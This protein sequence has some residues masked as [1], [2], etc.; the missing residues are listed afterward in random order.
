MLKAIDYEELVARCEQLQHLTFEHPKFGPTPLPASYPSFCEVKAHVVASRLT[1]WGISTR[2]I[3]AVRAEPLLQTVSPF[4]EARGEIHENPVHQGWG[5]HV[6]PLVDTLVDGRPT[7]RVIDPYFSS[8]PLTEEAWLSGMGVK[9]ASCNIFDGEPEKIQQEL[10]RDFSCNWTDGK[11]PYPTDRTLLIR[12]TLRAEDWPG[13]DRYIPSSLDEADR[14]ARKSYDDLHVAAERISRHKLMESMRTI[15]DRQPDLS[16]EQKAEQIKKIALD[17]KPEI[18]NTL[19]STYS[20]FN[21]RVQ[22]ELAQCYGD[23]ALLFESPLG[24]GRTRIL[25]GGW[26]IYQA[27]ELTPPAPHR[28]LTTVLPGG[29]QV[30]KG[31]P[32]VARS[33]QL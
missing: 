17:V 27:A 31:A 9:L 32:R 12:T 10:A 24:G 2:K 14:L 22:R 8:G 1:Q 25:P 5:F 18:R 4:D 16:S 33:R 26:E 20:D 13:P 28:S 6:A 19:L 11:F 29:W 23:V 15:V 21:K 7:T 3:F 30:Y